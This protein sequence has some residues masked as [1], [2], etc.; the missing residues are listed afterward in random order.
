MGIVKERNI[1]IGLIALFAVIV[2]S[3]SW[4]T[5]A[6]L[7]A[8]WVFGTNYLSELGV[9]EVKSA[10]MFFNGGCIVAGLL[11][12]VFGIG[13]TVSKKSGLGQTAGLLATVAGM[14]M[15]MVGVFPMDTNIHTPV[16]YAA[17]AL[18]GLF[19]AVLA[20][21][22][23]RD[24]LRILSSLAFIGILLTAAAYVVLTTDLVSINTRS[25]VGL[26]GVETA[27][28]LMLF[29]ML[30][31]HGM[32][33]LYNGAL[34]LSFLGKGIADRHTL[35]YGLALM[36]GVVIFLAFWLF[37]MLSC[38]SWAFGTDP[39]YALG[40]NEDSGTFFSI[41]VIGGGA[42]M[43]LYGAGVGMM[44]NGYARNMS[45]FFITVMGIC[46]ILNGIAMAA[47]GSISFEC[48]ECL[49]IGLGAAALAFII[50]S[51]WQHGRMLTASFYLIKWVCCVAA[52]LFLGYE[53]ASALSALV[54][55][56]VL[57]TE[58]VRLM[59]HR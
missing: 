26:P 28:A 4:Y 59:I 42:F 22:D 17:F 48:L 27:A 33:Y 56:A 53:A 35:A 8:D 18:A 7:D 14:A 25:F 29:V 12:A 36:L 38:P 13:L 43:V 23:W 54:F 10:G 51:D 3:V 58:A 49:M 32:K 57:G 50:I 47:G 39:L 20:I 55:F 41:A 2:F 24:G 6:M 1:F 11:F 44:H 37:A 30:S 52:L 5:A 40:L 45:G 34:D 31:L 15:A 21:K 46:L 9:S 16:A 19:I